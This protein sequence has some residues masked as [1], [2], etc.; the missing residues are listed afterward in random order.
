M[1]ELLARM[2]GK[3]VELICVGAV[4]LC[5]EVLK[6]SDGVLQF[7]DEERTVYVATE[8]IISIA[9]LNQKHEHRA[10]FIAS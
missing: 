4:R 1:E 7:K 2:K 3:E 10:G 9:E 5:G 6:V 8:K